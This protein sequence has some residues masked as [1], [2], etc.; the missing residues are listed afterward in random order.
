MLWRGM[1]IHLMYH[2]YSEFSESCIAA[3]VAQAASARLHRQVPAPAG[4][5]N[6]HYI[7]SQ[8]ID[9]CKTIFFIFAREGAI[10]MARK[11]QMNQITTPEL[12]AQV[13]PENIR[14][15]D[16]F[17]LYLQSIQRS[18]GTIVQYRSDLNIFFV[19]NLLHNDNKPFRD[20]K[21]RAIVAYQY[22]LINEHGN[23]PARVRRLKA[24]L[25]S[26][27]NYIDNILVGDDE[28]YD[29]F[30]PIIRKIENPPK[31]AV[32]EKTVLSEEQLLKLLNEL[33]RRG[34]NERACLVA[35][36]AYSGRRK[37]ELLRFK[38]SDFDDCN[39]VYGSLYRTPRQIKTKGRGTNG[40]MLTCYTLAKPFR[41]WFDFWMEEREQKGI[42]SEWLFPDP[43]NP[44]ES[45]TIAAI[46]G[47]TDEFSKILGEEV[48]MHSFRH[49]AC[50]RMVQAGIPTNVV[51][52]IF[53]WGSP[54]M[55]EV[56]SDLDLSD[57]IGKY[58]KDGDIVAQGKKTLSDL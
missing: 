24:V 39:V 6:R 15:R 38:V 32:R 31:A 11:T 1:A 18:A 45:R 14:L 46:S 12:M 16:D 54:D 22:W 51:Q 30:R 35:L 8:E 33:H 13:N 29:N 41:P 2:A 50:T 43:A 37:A 17:L 26:L 5:S 25:S 56:Y 19:F 44:K 57:E 20:V 27:S 55:V 40:K 36:A 23:S 10:A 49:M 53:G 48:Y 3:L 42:E 47:W 4:F 52:E 34:K 58:F 7:L 28:D 21:K 9:I